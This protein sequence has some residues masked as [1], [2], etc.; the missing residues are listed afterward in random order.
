MGDVARM[1]LTEHSPTGELRRT[2]HVKIKPYFLAIDDNDRVVISDWSGIVGVVDGNGDTLLTITP[3][4]NGQA[5][6][7]CGG[8]CTDMRGIYVAMDNGSD[9]GHIHHYDPQGNF[10]QCIA[11]GLR[12]P[13]GITLTADGQLAI[14]DWSSVKIYRELRS[15]IPSDI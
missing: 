8:V 10:V 15:D 7:S 3:T 11:E 2:I 4:I 12:N 13:Q 9:T 5:V 6:R 14:A 1:V